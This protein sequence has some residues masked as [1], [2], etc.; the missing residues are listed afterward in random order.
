[1]T[2]RLKRLR[3]T[4]RT[5]PG[6]PKHM[7]WVRG[8]KCCVDRCD[9]WPVIFHHVRS[10]GEAGMGE[11]DDRYG[12]PLCN[13]HHIELHQIGWRTFEAKHGLD[14]EALAEQLWRDDRAHG[15][16][17]EMKEQERVDG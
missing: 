15:A 16:F 10:A 8:F 13:D 7:K 1:M 5:R 3:R 12:A 2:C 4:N 6:Q 17:K 9:G 14:L 11:K